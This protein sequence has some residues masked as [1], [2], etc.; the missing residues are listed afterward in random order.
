M[1]WVVN[2]I[3]ASIE[4]TMAEMVRR[5]SLEPT[6]PTWTLAGSCVPLPESFAVRSCASDRFNLCEPRDMTSFEIESC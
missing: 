4:N 6:C 2:A 5:K 3:P 1:D